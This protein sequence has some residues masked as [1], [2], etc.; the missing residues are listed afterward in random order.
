MV[1]RVHGGGAAFETAMT[2]FFPRDSFQM[3]DDAGTRA[4][5]AGP[6]RLLSDGVVESPRTVTT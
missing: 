5:R 4:T 1:Y 3:A 6:T 2:P